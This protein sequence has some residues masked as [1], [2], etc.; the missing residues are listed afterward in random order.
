M[1]TET[2]NHK[3]YWRFILVW[4]G[5]LISTIGS[6]LTAF[7]LGVYAYQKTQTA[8][9]FALIT[10][11]TFLPSILLRPLGGVMAD[12]FDRRLMMVLGDLGSALGLIFILMMLNTGTFQMWYL[13]LGV[14]IS[15][16]FVAF[17]SPAYKSSVTDMLTEEQYAKASGLIQL[18]SSSQFLISPVVAG[19]LM[20]V[21]DIKTILL[22][23]I[24]TFLIAISAVLVIK[25]SLETSASKSSEGK[26]SLLEDLKEGWEVI[27]QRQG[28]LVLI[29]IISLVTLFVG[30]VQTLLG[31]MI[32]AF[33]NA[34]TLGTL[35]SLSATGMLVSSLY[36]GIF[37]K[38]EK[39]A[40]T[41]VISLGLGGFF[42][43]LLG[44]TTNL[45]LL[46]LGGFGFFCALPFINT[47]ADVLIR[48]NIEND[49]QGR[50]W[51]LIGIISQLGYIIA[52]C[53]A[54]FLADKVFNPL[55]VK[56]GILAPLLGP[57]IGMGKGRGIGVILI[58]S[59]ICTILIAI[60]TSRIKAI[61]RLEKE[62]L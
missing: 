55:M 21:T 52:Y 14:A 4:L 17:Q 35:Q 44:I 20:S 31:P 53:A 3:P 41:L 24:S 15:S 29:Y 46:T 40:R 27:S 50:V 6:G 43:A 1:A 36:I 60:I 59:G 45:M 25:K 19:F 49:K 58:L 12:R 61:T 5:Q 2:N 42:F 16:F 39:M 47:A 33:S 37:S 57:L 26:A 13:Y 10:L 56:G 28:V 51:G 32:L 8:T 7:A 34:R 48:K 9:S 11:F 30:F 38:S 54:G 62:S 23:D 18:A 22:I